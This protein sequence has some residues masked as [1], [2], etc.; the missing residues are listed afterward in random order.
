MQIFI[1]VNKNGSVSIH[2]I[3]PVRDND[4]GIWISSHPYINSVVQKNIDNMIKHSSM[5]WAM[6]PEIIEIDMNRI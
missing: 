1:G 2:T 3:E 5:T 6:E 4:K